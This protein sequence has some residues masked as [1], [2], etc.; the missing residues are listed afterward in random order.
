MKTLK[1]IYNNFNTVS[2]VDGGD[3]G[4]IH[5]YIDEYYEVAL[6][7]Y[8]ESALKVLEIG[9]NQGH[10][11]MMWK[12]YFSNAEII[13]VDLLLPT[14]DTGCRMIKGDATDPNTFVN[15]DNIDVIIDDG[16]HL[17]KHQIKSFNLLFSKLN[18]GGIYIIEDIKNI[19]A[20][21]E[22]F[23]SLHPTAKIFDFRTIKNRSDDIIVEIKK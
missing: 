9:I 17:F 23:L 15:I 1:E 22:A 16:S 2:P 20:C 18:K 19:D 3:K 7:P 12:E 4:T 14:T 6:A 21:K 10:S 5:S 11:L 8:R 13:G